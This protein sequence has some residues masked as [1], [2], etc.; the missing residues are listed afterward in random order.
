MSW[1]D[2]ACL[3]VFIAGFLIFLYASNTYNNLVGFTG[4]YM[5]F[6]AI[7]AYVVIFVYKDLTK[8]PAVQKP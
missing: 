7:I 1:T 6:G 4:L 5:W 8:K 2:W 3:G